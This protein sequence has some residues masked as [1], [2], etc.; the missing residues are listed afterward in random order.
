MGCISRMRLLTALRQ[1]KIL[2]MPEGSLS[3][4]LSRSWQALEA[5]A[6]GC[7]VV[8]SDQALLPPA[9]DL[10]DSCP[11]NA[12]LLE[13]SLAVLQDEVS[14]SRASL[15]CRREILASHTYAHRIRT[16][17]ESINRE[18]DWEEHPLVSVIAPTKR[19][20]LIPACLESF[21]SQVYPNKEL[22]LMVNDN[23]VDMS[24]LREQLKSYSNVQVFQ[25]HQEKNIGTCLN[26]GVSKANGKYWF[27]MDDDDFYGPRYLLDMVHLAEAADF[28]IIG[29]PTAFIYLQSEDTIY[30]RSNACQRQHLIG[31]MGIPHLCGATFGGTRACY[32]GFSEIRRACVDSY[33][34]D[35]AR[36]IGQI[37][38][39]GDIWNFIAYR[40]AD[41]SVHTWRHHDGIITQKATPYAQGKATERIMI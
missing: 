27:K 7:S 37:V 18:H 6:C 30:L 14:R 8:S 22:L 40:A 13:Q 2:L 9:R 23:E 5:L 25:I 1:Y 20:D 26:L 29:K 35:N 36:E 17:C 28:H 16:I 33:F 4:G 32:P 39:S 24:K 10:I 38:I 12:S 41:K 19:P 11:D 15:Q 31:S 3:S 34:I 21:E